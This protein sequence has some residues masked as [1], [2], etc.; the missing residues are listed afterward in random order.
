MQMERPSRIPEQ[1]RDIGH[2]VIGR[3]GEVYPAEHQGKC[4]GHRQ[5]AS[6]ENQ[7]VHRPAQPRAAANEILG[8]K[9]QSPPMLQH[10]ANC[11]APLVV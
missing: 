1:M 9:V 4:D 2:L 7:L 11:A 5:Q 3:T 6:P 10:S 8:K